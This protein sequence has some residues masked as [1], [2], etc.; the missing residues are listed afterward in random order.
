LK[1][2]KQRPESA[3]GGRCKRRAE[4]VALLAIIRCLRD[5]RRSAGLELAVVDDFLDKHP[6]APRL[7]HPVRL[8]RKMARRDQKGLQIRTDLL[9]LLRRHLD[10]G[11]TVGI[12]ALADERQFAPFRHER[13]YCA[14]PF[15]Y[16]AS[17]N[18]ELEGSQDIGGLFA[19]AVAA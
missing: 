14:D 8:G 1:P 17:N 13:C 18:R 15:V 3:S 11:F 5:R 19:L 6:L 9:I 7:E 2:E 16:F 12:P 4:V 10:H